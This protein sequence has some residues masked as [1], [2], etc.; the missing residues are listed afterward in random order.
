[1]IRIIKRGSGTKVEPLFS[2]FVIIKKGRID[3]D[4]NKFFIEINYIENQPLP[5]PLNGQGID[6][7]VM[8]RA[9]I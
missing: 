7:K 4:L 9:K 2:F 6:A 1:M 5:K 8:M 3:I